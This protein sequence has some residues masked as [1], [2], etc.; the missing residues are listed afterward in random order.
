MR[1]YCMSEMADTP[2]V[3]ISMKLGLSESLEAILLSEIKSH[4]CLSWGLVWTNCWIFLIRVGS[5]TETSCN[6]SRGVWSYVQTIVLENANQLQVCK[7][8]MKKYSELLHLT[9]CKQK[10][11]QFC[12]SSI[13]TVDWLCQC[14]IERCRKWTPNWMEILKF[15]VISH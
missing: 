1:A 6:I 8:H 9:E 13:H 7:F 2:Q 4:S 12:A 15:R 11:T 3:F 10:D 5:R 14:Y